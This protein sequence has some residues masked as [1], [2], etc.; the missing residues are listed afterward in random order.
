MSVEHFIVVNMERSLRDTVNFLKQSAEQ[1]SFRKR[2]GA[3]F[4]HVNFLFQKNTNPLRKPWC[5]RKKSSVI[6]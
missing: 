3:M 5:V 6:W 2:G 1:C 4:L